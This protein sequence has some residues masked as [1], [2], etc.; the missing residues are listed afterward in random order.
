MFETEI[1]IAKYC[2]W[3]WKRNSGITN[4]KEQL[5]FSRPQL[6]TLCRTSLCLSTEKQMFSLCPGSGRELSSC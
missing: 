5:M 2:W 1:S 3:K 4:C 6:L